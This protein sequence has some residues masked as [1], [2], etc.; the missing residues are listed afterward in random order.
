MAFGRVDDKA[1]STQSHDVLLQEVGLQH[2]PISLCFTNLMT[3]TPLWLPYHF[4]GSL[5]K[6]KQAKAPSR[7][8]LKLS[9]AY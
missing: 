8:T 2:Y 4:L 6:S 5:L 3:T 9:P 1:G 7:S